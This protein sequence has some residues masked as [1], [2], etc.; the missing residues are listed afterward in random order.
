[1]RSNYI[2]LVIVGLLLFGVVSVA[3][4]D[5]FTAITSEEL[6][7]M[8]ERKEQHLVLV[9]TRSHGEYQDA[10]IKGALNIPWARLEKDPSALNFPKD[11]NLLFYCS[12]SS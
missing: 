6:R 9:D 12:G 7:A 5:V 11:S 8:I 4:A 10:H 1:M 3:A 2:L